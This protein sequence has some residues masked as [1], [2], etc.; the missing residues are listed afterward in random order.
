MG[1]FGTQS[2]RCLWAIEQR[3]LLGKTREAFC[4]S[5]VE[6]IT[7]EAG[8]WCWKEAWSPEY[9]LNQSGLYSVGNREPLKSF[10]QRSDIIKFAF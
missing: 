6:F 2:L 10:E 7:V 5:S 9:Q 3:F 1:W 8:G 4:G